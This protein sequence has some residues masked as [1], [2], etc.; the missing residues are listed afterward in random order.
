MRLTH[1]VSYDIFVENPLKGDT[2]VIQKSHN[3][4]VS[5]DSCAKKEFGNVLKEKR[6]LSTRIA[7]IQKALNWIYP[8]SGGTKSR[9]L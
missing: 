4:S 3:V 6:T 2:N 9:A 7:G 5:F 8:L 1:L